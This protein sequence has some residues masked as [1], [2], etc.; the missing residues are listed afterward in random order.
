MVCEACKRTDAPLLDMH[1]AFEGAPMACW[2][3]TSYLKTHKNT[4]LSL[5]TY[6]HP[7]RKSCKQGGQGTILAAGWTSSSPDV[8]GLLVHPPN[9][10][11]K[12]H[13]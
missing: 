13:E 2:K 4:V 12:R 7:E 6:L 10:H 11:A 5:Q 8:V 1:A 9:L 3:L